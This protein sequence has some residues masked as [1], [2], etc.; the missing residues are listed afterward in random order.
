MKKWCRY[1]LMPVHAAMIAS[2][3]KSFR[4]NPVIGSARL[5]RR[6]LHLARRHLAQRM[7]ALRRSR[8]AGLISAQDRADFE[9][10]GFLPMHFPASLGELLRFA[11][12]RRPQVHYHLNALPGLATYLLAMRAGSHPSRFPAYAAAMAPLPWSARPMIMPVMVWAVA[13]TTLPSA[14][15]TRPKAITRL[16]PRRSDAMP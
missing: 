16:R 3:A 8:L 12:N 4:D 1:L 10:D 2:G 15:S 13:A 6:G 9:R 7:G 5:N 11:G 14:N